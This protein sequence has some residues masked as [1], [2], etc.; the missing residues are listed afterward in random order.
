MQLTLNEQLIEL[1]E[2]CSLAELLFHYPPALPLFAVVVNEH[3][4]AK[5]FYEKKQLQSG[6]RITILFPMQGG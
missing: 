2:L 4:V 1:P 3:F 6:D 5:A